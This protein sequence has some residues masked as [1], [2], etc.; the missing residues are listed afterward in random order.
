MIWDEVQGVQLDLSG[1]TDEQINEMIKIMPLEKRQQL[2][3]A[4]GEETK[5]NEKLTKAAQLGLRIAQIA[6]KLI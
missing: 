2:I 6:L 3:A 4:L 1:L 5:N